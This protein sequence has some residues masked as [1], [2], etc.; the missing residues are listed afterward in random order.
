LRAG[1]EARAALVDGQ[2]LVE[3]RSRED[4]LIGADNTITLVFRNGTTVDIVGTLRSVGVD[5]P[6][7]F[8][9]RPNYTNVIKVDTKNIDTSLSENTTR[10]IANLRNMRDNLAE[11]GATERNFLPLWMRTAQPGSVQE[12]GF[13]PAI[14]LC[15][16]KPGTSAT[17]KN[18]IDFYNFNFNQFDFDVDR[19]I[20]DGTLGNSNEQ[21]LLFANYQFNV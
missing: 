3:L 7:S 20:I 6:A 21:Y 2:V 14:P 4:R 5:D 11:V 13:T 9:F 8:S 15:Y 19:Y 10:Y 12:L 16:C 18:S 1:T 17:I